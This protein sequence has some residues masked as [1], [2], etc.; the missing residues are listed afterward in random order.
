LDSDTRIVQ[1]IGDARNRVLQWVDRRQLAAWDTFERA[2]QTGLGT[3]D[4]G[5]TWTV[6]NGTLNIVSKLAAVQATTSPTIATLDG[7]ITSTAREIRLRSFGGQGSGWS[8]WVV[9]YFVDLDNYV[10]AGW[11][12]SNVMQI[13]V[14]S[15]SVETVAATI[16]YPATVAAKQQS[17]DD[18]TVTVQVAFGST[19]IVARAVN[20]AAG[21]RFSISTDADWAAKWQ[22]NPVNGMRLTNGILIRA[23]MFAVLDERTDEWA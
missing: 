16:T 5:H 18:L 15:A 3:S 20:A 13:V 6:H 4:S 8:N 14:R 19:Q 2:N 21:V 7:T 12:A 23:S 9:P 22:P 17:W 1:P 11:N 10:R